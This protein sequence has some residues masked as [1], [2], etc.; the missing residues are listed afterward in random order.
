M[1]E[2]VFCFSADIA[3]HRL[4]LLHG[5]GANANDLIPLGRELIKPLKYNVELVFLN[6][7]NKQADEGGQ[8]W[9]ELFPAHWEQAN[10]AVETLKGRLTEIICSSHIPLQKTVLLGFSQG[11][12][13][14]IAAGVEL[15][16]AGLIGC[17]AYP[18]PGFQ[19]EQNIAPVFLTHGS[20]DAVVPLN[21][22]RKLY[23]LLGENFNN[24][25]LYIF[26]GGHEI[27]AEVVKKIQVFLNQ[28]LI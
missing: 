20:Q 16:L 11:G 18:H 2:E 14:A 4:I 22:S 23:E 27:S 13:M 17:S 12:A 26:D 6:A 21:A 19:P 3:T 24:V 5:W 10:Q 15:P 25:E 8:Q 28:V 9:Y 7:P 1:E